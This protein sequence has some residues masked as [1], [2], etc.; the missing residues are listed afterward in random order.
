M[1]VCRDLLLIKKLPCVK[2][3]NITLVLVYEK[4]GMVPLG[5]A[6]EPFQ[7]THLCMQRYIYDIRDKSF[8]IKYKLL[9]LNRKVIGLFSP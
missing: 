4:R 8:R 5:K 3:I 2:K 9:P 7:L 1:H 6:G